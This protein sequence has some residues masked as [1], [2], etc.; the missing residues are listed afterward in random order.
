MNWHK[1]YD[2][3]DNNWIVYNHNW[4]EEFRFETEGLADLMLFCLER[5]IS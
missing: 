1:Q 3:E 4:T 5:A 2:V